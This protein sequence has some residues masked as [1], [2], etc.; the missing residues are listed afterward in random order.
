MTAL[1]PALYLPLMVFRRS[2]EKTAHDPP[3]GLL[4]VPLTES[5][6]VGAA[7]PMPTRLA[8]VSTSGKI[9]NK[10]IF[11]LFEVQSSSG[12]RSP[13]SHIAV[14]RDVDTAGRS[15]GTNAEREARTAGYIADKKV[16][17]VA[18]DIPGLR[19]KTSGIILFESNCRSVTR[20]CMH[21]QNRSRSPE[22]DLTVAGDLE[23]VCRC[24]GIDLEYDR[25]GL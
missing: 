19:R 8:L 20:I 10:T 4:A 15:A 1:S 22:S 3:P 23:R 11:T 13:Q 7:V 9:A 16:R 17:F 2:S 21:I 24:S 12:T 25:S 6:S 14:G 5:R 18:R